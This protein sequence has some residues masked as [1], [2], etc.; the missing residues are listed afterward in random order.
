M[1]SGTARKMMDWQQQTAANKQETILGA[2]VGWRKISDEKGRGVF[3]LRDIKKGEVIEVAPV[4]TVS[5]ENV[6]EN[7]EAPDGYLLQWDEDTEGEEFCMPL[8]YIMLYNHAAEASM[9]MENDMEEYTITARAARDI[10]TGEE[11]TWN[12]ACDIWFDEKS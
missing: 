12:Y 7:G 3:A 4:V 5:K 2:S 9:E 10:K 6:I 1:K 11:L 8:G